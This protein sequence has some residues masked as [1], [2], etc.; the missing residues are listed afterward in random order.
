MASS[1]G[2]LSLLAI[3]TIFVVVFAAMYGGVQYARGELIDH[4]PASALETELRDDLWD[5]I[6]D[7]RATR[8]LDPAQRD[9]ATR[10]GAQETAGR[11]TTMAYFG[12]PTAA[13]IRPEADEPLPNRMGFCY[14]TPV[15]LT[16]EPTAGGENGADADRHGVAGVPTR[17]VAEQVVELLA[18]DASTDVFSRSNDQKHGLGVVVSGDVVYVVYRTCALGY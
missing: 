16:V 4:E 2:G 17:I 5:V 1:R 11:L 12:E 14:Q 10:A 9:S 7:E 3:G 6:N 15:K 18:S 8:G 13:G